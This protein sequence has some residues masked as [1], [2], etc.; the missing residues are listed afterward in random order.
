[1]PVLAVD[2]ASL[3]FGDTYIGYD[4]QLQLTVSNVGTDLLSVTDIVSGLGDFT[5]TPTMF[6]LD[7]FASMM[8]TVNFAPTAE[9]VLAT[10]LQLVSNDANSPMIVPV[11]GVGVIPPDIAWSP[12]PV[13]GAAM[14][15]GQK[16]KTLQVCNEG[17][18]DLIFTVNASE[19]LAA[20]MQQYPYVEL[21]KEEEDPRPG[22]LGS[23]GPDTF[24]HTWIDS[25]DPDG[26]VFAWTDI[27]TTG[28]A[29]FGSYS[30]DG[31]RGPFPIGFDFGFYG[32]EFSDF[33]VCSN[34]WLS[35]TSTSTAYSNQP[36]PNGGAPE[37]L[38]APF[39][40]DM[41]VDPVTRGLD[42]YYQNDG[43]KLIV[44]YDIRRIATFDPPY[45]SFQVILY[46]NG[47]IKF[48]YD[49]LGAN[50]TSATV[51]IQNATKDDA[52]MMVYNDDYVH[53]NLAV[54][55]SSAPSWLSS[56]PESGVIPPARRRRLPR[57]DDRRRRLGYRSRYPEPRQQRQVDDQLCRTAGGVRSRGRGA[58]DSPVERG[59]SCR[60]EVQRL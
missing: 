1:V 56:A 19:S 5:A 27:S 21:A 35:F 54:L 30:D 16:V 38:I 23:G 41:V 10:D 57:G 42:I 3:D 25:D 26:P 36:L 24:G 52:L 60:Y 12:D 43:E 15:G 58:G 31:N 46:P 6:D 45:Y 9:G 28:T 14:P 44:Q 53:E 51:G 2:P 4:S 33:N 59:G 18:S 34:G 7:P 50:T 47:N 40:D 37:N 39:W 55:I 17:G 49:T 11:T 29:C 22:I 13:V 8:V 20:D 48:Q 32:N